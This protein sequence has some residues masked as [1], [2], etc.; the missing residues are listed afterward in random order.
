[1]DHIGIDVHKNESQICILREDGTLVE[2][3]IRTERGRFH[4]TLGKGERA[5]IVIEAST[6]SEWVPVP[7]MGCA[8]RVAPQ[9]HGR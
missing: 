5:R 1:M 8:V 4:A 6:E 3:R 7:R 2:C 9:H